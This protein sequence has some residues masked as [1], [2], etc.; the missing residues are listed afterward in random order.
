MNAEA[1]AI[2]RAL[3]L[4]TPQTYD[5]NGVLAEQPETRFYLRYGTGTDKMSHVERGRQ[6]REKADQLVREIERGALICIERA[7]TATLGGATLCKPNFLYT[8]VVKGHTIALLRRGL[9]GARVVCGHGIPPQTLPVFQ[10]WS[11]VQGE[12]YTWC[13]SQGPTVD[14]A[15]DIAS[16]IQ[17]AVPVTSR[18]ILLE[19]LFTTTGLV[20]CD[21]RRGGFDQFGDSICGITEALEAIVQAG[22]SPTTGGPYYVDGF[23]VDLRPSPPD[24][25]VL[26]ACN[27]AVLSH[28][29]TRCRKRPISIR[30]WN[31]NYAGN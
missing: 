17:D 22:S 30:L 28:F 16:Q 9:C 29:V 20:F 15:Q 27:G 23:D 10:G 5:L 3:G 31:G 12:S 25:S 11:A 6:I 19:W 21:A 26:L 1:F 24:G 4:R 14:E 7:Y 8:E 2:L 13:P 18:S